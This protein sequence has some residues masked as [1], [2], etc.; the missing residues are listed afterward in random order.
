LPAHV[1]NDRGAMVARSRST[2]RI[3]SRS[4]AEHPLSAT[5]GRRARYRLDREREES[6]KGSFLWWERDAFMAEVDA[7]GENFQIGPDVIVDPASV[8][9][10]EP[11]AAR[12]LKRHLTRSC[13]EWTSSTCGA[14]AM[15]RLWLNW[16]AVAPGCVSL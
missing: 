3:S 7:V 4:E 1:Q 8:L 12:P 5:Q 13:S 9:V 2:T 16:H 11:R 14:T 15:P 10:R 6:P